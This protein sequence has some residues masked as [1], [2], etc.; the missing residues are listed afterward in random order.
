MRLSPRVPWSLLLSVA[1]VAVCLLALS[2]LCPAV[3]QAQSTVAV[4]GFELDGNAP[5][6]GLVELMRGELERDG[7][8]WVMPANEV[9]ARFGAGQL[10][11]SDATTREIVSELQRGVDAFFA[12]DLE[13]AERLL[14]SAT[15]RAINAPMLLVVDP[16]LAEATKSALLTLPRVLGARAAFDEADEALLLFASTFPLAQV[17]SRQHPPGIVDALARVRS[18]FAARANRLWL[19]SVGRNESCSVNL[20]GDNLDLSAGADRELPV[21]PKDHGVLLRCGELEAGPFQVQLVRSRQTLPV[22]AGLL[23]ALLP[24]QS[25]RP[26]A[27]PASFDERRDLGV[28]LTTLLGVDAVVLVGAGG[29]GLLAAR[30][31]RDG[32]AVVATL[33]GAAHEESVQDLVRAL[34][35]GEPFGALGVDTAGHG[36]AYAEA[37]SYIVE[38][39]G[40]GVAGAMLVTGG[41]FLGLA[42]HQLDVVRDCQKLNAC[43]RAT[44]QDNG[45]LYTTNL[46][47]GQVLLAVGGAVALA[48][49]TSLLIRHLMVED[50]AAL[51]AA[52]GQPGLAVG[53]G[54]AFAT[55]SIT[56]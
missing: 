14:D 46:L 5:P 44:E 30:V 23:Q 11:S 27:L 21:A 36:F 43:R 13:Q 29:D 51:G 56:W 19:R 55:W 6:D 37:P 47:T 26:V 50:E 54:E 2:A 34:E 1:A 39:V 8:T 48:A 12:D 9:A 18:E 31:T 32:A 40:F 53:A 15:A 45:D 22:S 49:G 16:N 42:S 17:S 10:A 41:V 52:L 20:Q 3:A 33:D 4:V 38:Y 28:L 24:T 7:R 35:R 25:G